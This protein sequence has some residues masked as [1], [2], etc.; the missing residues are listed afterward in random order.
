MIGIAA[1]IALAPFANLSG[2]AA[3]DY[4]A[5][6]F[7]EDVA[8]ELSRFGTLE[9]VYPRAVESMAKRRAAGTPDRHMAGHMLR[10]SV[11]RGGDVIR[12]TAQLVE[13]PTGRQVWADRYDATA[14]NLLAV[15]DE[16]AARIAGALAI[17]VDETRLA[18]ARRR[19]LASLETY[20]CWLRGFEC[21]QR[22]TVEAD[23]EA[24]RF[25]ERALEIDPAY[26]RAYTGLSLSHFNEWSCQAWEKWDEKERLAYEHARRAADLDD[27]DAV[28]QVVLGRILLY[29]RRFD[30]GAYHVGRA[31]ALNANHT[32]VLVHAALCRAYLG[33]PEHALELAGKAMRLSPSYPPWYA[34]PSGLALFLLG[35]D[36][37]V[38]QLGAGAATS[39]FVDAPAFLAAACALTGDRDR[40]RTYLSQFLAELDKRVTF[41]RTP[42]PGE[43][44][45]WL[46]HI[47]PFR[48]EEDADRLARGLRAAGLEGDPDENRPEAVP[49]PVVREAVGGTFRQEDGFWSITF[50]GLAVQLTSQ[51]GFKDLARLLERPGEEIHCLELADRPAETGRPSPVLD[52]RA[53][54]EVHERI[55]EL[56]REI[57]D[58]DAA[59]DIGRAERAREE[60]DSIVELLSGALGL[61]GRPRALGSA[62]E[63][64]RSAVTWRIRSAIKKI[65][66]SHPRLGRHLEN[67]VR[68]GTFCAYM[69]ETLIDW[70]L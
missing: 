59:N 64:A 6:G 2:D 57:D 37:E 54:R 12:I 28:V 30:E 69:P 9:V 43:P 45:R 35:R 23:H 68:T 65:A 24:R 34:A 53:R 62:A 16:I 38:I 22:G 8:T 47:N 27:G 1:S 39:M 46:L 41:G 21:L 50:D 49:H 55:L 31:L 42:D 61:G 56:Q 4:L 5:R 58:A 19:P 20:E 17:R 7:V 29:R 70:S 66:A 13:T 10:G 51:K 32:D 67:T 14:D 3:Q 26:A 63:R 44:L 52:D 18:E 40:A 33:D 60:L 11:R 25:F 48:R 15:Q 36:A